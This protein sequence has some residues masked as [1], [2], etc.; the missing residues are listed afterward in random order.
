MP[1]IPSRYREPLRKQFPYD[2]DFYIPGY[3]K[4]YP[5]GRSKTLAL[6]NIDCGV[7]FEEFFNLVIKKI[8]QPSFFPI[9]RIS[10]GEFIFFLGEQP[11]DVRTTLTQ[12]IIFFLSRVKYSFLLK[13]GLGAFTHG[14]SG[15]YHSGLYT[16]N[17]WDYAKKNY[18]IWLKKISIDGI[19][20]LHLNYEEVPFA[21]RYYPIFAKFIEL[22]EIEIN[23]N[24]Y[25]PFYFVYA[26]LT[27]KRKKEL[28][29]N[30]RVLVVNG[31]EEDKKN[32]VIDALY[33]EGVCCVY[34][35]QISSD[36]SLF[37]IVDVL[38]Y[39]GK[40]DFILLGAGI[41]KP[42]I[43]YQLKL[44]N[45]LIIDA[46]FIFETWANPNSINERPF[47]KID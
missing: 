15:K 23:T 27:C 22:N 46:G 8:N 31:F 7:W 24:N 19:L 37:D 11:V 47:C 13:G 25:Y 5:I 30:R 20:A 39:K 3:I 33:H 12:K 32:K 21:E 6:K 45:T 2:I 28:F 38:K 36:R 43:I 9:C 26:L 1:T 29:Q 14:K 40:I 35:E 4:S 42:N 16:K 17:E 34:W 41:G 44:L 18:I 10:D